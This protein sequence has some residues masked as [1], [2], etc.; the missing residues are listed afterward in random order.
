MLD[1]I[2]KR[3]LIVLYWCSGVL[4]LIDTFL[5]ACKGVVRA[6]QAIRL[7][8]KREQEIEQFKIDQSVPFLSDTIE[9]RSKK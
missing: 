7:D 6:V 5:G 3:A 4:P 8:D 2:C 1:K 9:E